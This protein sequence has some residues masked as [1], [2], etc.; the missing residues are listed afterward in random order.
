MS[1]KYQRAAQEGRIFGVANQAAIAVTAALATTFTGLAV[2]NPAASGVDCVIVNMS[3]GNTVEGISAGTIGIMGA[4]GAITASLTPKNQRLGGPASKVTATGGQTIATPILYK[5]V[6][7]SGTGAITT[8]RAGVV[9]CDL[10]GS[11]VV[12]PGYFWATYC[13]ALAAASLQF[14]FTWEEVSR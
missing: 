11:I 5:L 14:S 10:D 7:H 13:F 9:S 6:G 3:F 4:A 8:W 1:G 12:P 2:G